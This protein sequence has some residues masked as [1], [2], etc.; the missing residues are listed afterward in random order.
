MNLNYSFN[1]SIFIQ[2]SYFWNT[3]KITVINFYVNFGPPIQLNQ[4]FVVL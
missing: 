3:E 1:Y 2:F 4:S